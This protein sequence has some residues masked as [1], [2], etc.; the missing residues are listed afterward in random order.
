MF[1]FITLAFVCMIVMA[2]VEAAKLQSKNMIKAKNQAKALANAYEQLQETLD[3][4]EDNEEINQNDFDFMGALN[5]G[6]GN[7]KN[8]FH[9]WAW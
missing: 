3:V 1:K 9:F 2:G 4:M 6:L 5:K 8:M 7:L